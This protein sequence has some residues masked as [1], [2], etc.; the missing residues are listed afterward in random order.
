MTELSSDYTYEKIN[1]IVYSNHNEK[2]KYS[3]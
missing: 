3:N 1:E 2:I